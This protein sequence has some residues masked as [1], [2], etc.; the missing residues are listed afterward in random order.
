ML[1]FDNFDPFY[2]PLD[3]SWMWEWQCRDSMGWCPLG[4]FD[5]L[6]M[7]VVQLSHNNWLRFK[8]FPAA[9]PTW[10][11]FWP[12]HHSSNMT[13]VMWCH[14]MWCDVTWCDVMSRG[15]PTCNPYS[16]PGQALLPW[17][18]KTILWAGTLWVGKLTEQY[19]VMTPLP[20]SFL[21]LPHS[22]QSHD[23]HFKN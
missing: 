12:S 8:S 20:P 11:C 22:Q 2:I 18:I 17:W 10:S 1:M 4:I 3:F 21:L 6:K 5:N 15:G 19:L 13:R 23:K 9:D 16:P 14:G 7:T